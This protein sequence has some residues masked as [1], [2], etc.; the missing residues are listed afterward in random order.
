MQHHQCENP[1]WNTANAGVTRTTTK[2]LLP[3]RVIEVTENSKVDSSC[4]V[5]NE[6][7]QILL[8]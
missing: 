6:E 7:P 1:E 2:P 3:S 4:E 8:T 5:K